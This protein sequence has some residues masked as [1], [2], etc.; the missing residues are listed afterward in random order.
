VDFMVM[1]ALK[2]ARWD[3]AGSDSSVVLGNQGLSSYP[4]QTL[5]GSTIFL[6]NPGLGA[7]FEF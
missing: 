5:T 7:R 1:V 6:V 4:E 3:S 2:D